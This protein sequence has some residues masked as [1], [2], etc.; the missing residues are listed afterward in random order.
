MT[1]P[2]PPT[3]ASLA[4]L[5]TI[6]DVFHADPLAIRQT[7]RRVPVE[8]ANVGRADLPRLFNACGFTV[9]AEIGVKCGEFSE[10]LCK[11]MPGLKL[12]CVDPWITYDRYL[13]FTDQRKLNHNYDE[14]ARRLVP[15]DATLI[16][17]FSVEAAG[18]FADGSLDF[19]YI[20]GN[21]E[22]SAVA[23]DLFAWTP[24]VRSG[25]IIAGHDYYRHAKPVRHCHVAECVDGWTEAWH[26]SP[27][28]AL[29]RRA[30]DI[31]GEVRDRPRSFMWVNV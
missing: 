31:P 19:V 22:F 18:D 3:A 27:Y 9:G 5:Q 25:G 21:H 15:Y 29:G 30:C 24:K 26:I 1:Q 2:L 12:S 8:I 17:K 20:D 14:T 16:R 4:T 28:F 10:V 11:G 23:A 7:V 6:V 13:D